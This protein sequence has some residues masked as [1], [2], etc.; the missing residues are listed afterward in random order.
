VRDL[1]EFALKSVVAQPDQVSVSV[2]EGSASLLFEVEVAEGDRQ[3]L[4]AHDRA[5]LG[6]VQAVLSASSGRQKAVL[7]LRGPSDATAD[8]E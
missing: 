3:R 1:V 4:L 8:E 7:D 6:S 2:V 5:L